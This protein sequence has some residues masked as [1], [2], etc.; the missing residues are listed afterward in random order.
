MQD[1]EGIKRL[2]A[3]D[4][5]KDVVIIGGGLI[6]VEVTEALVSKGCRVTIVE[7]L[8]QI[9]GMLDWEMARLVTQHMEAKGV[10]VL[11]D[12]T[13]VKF[14]GEG[15]VEKVVTDKE[16]LAADMV[17]M[18]IGVRPAVGLA[19]DAGLAIGDFR[20]LVVDGTMKTSDDNIYAV[21]DCVES[22]DRI[23]GKACYMTMGSTANKHGRVAANNICGRKDIFPGVLGSTVCK[24]FDF[25]VGRTGLTEAAAKQEGYD[26]E[27]V[28]APG[29]DRAH[30]MEN[31]KPL[32]L[33]LVVDKKT[34]KLLGA[35]ATGPGDVDKRIDVA[36][37]T[38]AAKMTVDD[39]ANMDLCYAPPYSP[40]MDN[41]ITAANVARNKL[42]GYIEGISAKEVH[43]M[44]EAKKDF[45]FL[46][47][48]SQAESDEVRLSNSTLIPLGALRLRID[49]LP[50][51]KEIIAFCKI[52]LRGYEAA[53]IL[54]AAGFK[55]VRVMDGGVVMWPYRKEK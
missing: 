7:K 33:K 37:M 8:P 50:K 46:D 6:G 53:L 44:K 14:E 15:A 47:V 40:A 20:A 42:D 11:T 22:K 13:V 30:F 3:E 5:A 10:K 54:K 2:L 31:A 24:V 17:V 29:P 27:V 41:I 32:L 28:L 21:G 43:E 16:T 49:E 36:A 23:T 34:R 26:V 19:K 38:L 1:A 9:F 51:N 25:T 12:H 55:K 39:L 48:R 18:A 45:V 35:Q 52:S 4:Q